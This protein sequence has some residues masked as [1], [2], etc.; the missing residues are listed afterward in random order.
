MTNI[1]SSLD[2][3]IKFVMPFGAVIGD[4]IEVP[5]QVVNRKDEE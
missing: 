2:G 4:I 3:Y 5:V 1:Y